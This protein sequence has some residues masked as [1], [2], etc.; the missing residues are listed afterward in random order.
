MPS[1]NPL[2]STTNEIDLQHS[3]DQV[4]KAAWNT[5]Y[6]AYFDEMLADALV[7]R[8]M[9]ID[10]IVKIAT[11]MTAAGSAIAGWT[12]WNQPNLKPVWAILA[13]F[14][15]VCAIAH[16]ALGVSYRL[17]DYTDSKNRL[18]RL[19]IELETFRIKMAV[20]PQ[21]S[22]DEF[23]AELLRFRERWSNDSFK[24]NDL[25]AT[26]RLRTKLRNELVDELKQTP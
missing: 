8:W 21:F 14:G 2:T 7:R 26:L 25:L 18:A 16:T 4:W 6:Y 24:R 13:G 1:Q 15:A 12:F 11:A 3:R 19:R 22:V 20:D 17:K 9:R 5:Y 23:D 10:D